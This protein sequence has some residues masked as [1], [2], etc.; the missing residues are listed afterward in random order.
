MGQLNKTTEKVNELLDKV[1]GM[2]EEVKDG[3][4]PVLETGTTTTLDPGSDAT[5]EVVANGTDESGNPKYKL[6]FGIPKGYDGA[7]GSG[8]G[9]TADSVQWA[10]VLNK[11]SWVNSATKPTYTASEVGALPASS[12]IPSKTSQLTNDSG[13]TTSASFKTING[14]SIVGSGNIAIEGGGGNTPSAGGGNVNVTNGSALQSAN[15]Y[16]FKPSA[17]GSLDGTFNVIP[18]ANGSTPGLMSKEDYSK[19]DDMKQVWKIPVAVLE[20]T[21]NS[22]SDEIVTAFGLELSVLESYFMY[23]ASA[24]TNSEYSNTV[25]LKCFIGNR[26]CLMSGSM[27]D[28][29]YTLDFNYVDSGKLKI[30]SITYNSSTTQFS[31]KLSES[32]GGADDTY[33]L[34]TGLVTNLDA[35]ATDEEIVRA[36]GG[37]EK[38]QEII[39]FITNETYSHYAFNSTLFNMTASVSAILQLNLR[40]YFYHIQKKVKRTIFIQRD[41]TGG[42]VQ[43]IYTSGYA[44]RPE[45]YLLTS[46]SESA[47]ISTAVGGESGL[48]EII[49]AIKDGNRLVIRGKND[50]SAG[51]QTNQDLMC[52]MYKEEENGDILL[53]LSGIGYGLFGGIAG[54]LSINYTKSS[55]TFSCEY[56]SIR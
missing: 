3:K 46:S 35:G 16:A 23:S 50:S 40:I 15:Y 13:F 9:G 25:P 17:D 19:L 7:G 24:I 31:C 45:V 1:D 32:G 10:K 54:F 27:A 47:D 5:S 49:Q 22:T 33:Y 12:T 48:K 18:N 4:T 34:P 29:A 2:P 38:I 8:G 44:L 42:F 20:L 21:D 43:D 36:F 30:I 6:N 56:T 51:N 14:Q 41:G 37:V 28:N 11:P 53:V 39:G 52:N 26:E 55:N